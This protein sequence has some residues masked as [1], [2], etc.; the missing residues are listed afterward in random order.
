MPPPGPMRRLA[1]QCQAVTAHHL[2]AAAAPFPTHLREQLIQGGLRGLA[3]EVAHVQ[4]GVLGGAGRRSGRS[5]RSLC[6]SHVDGGGLAGGGAGRW[7]WGA[8]LAADLT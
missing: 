3:I 1:G 5:W 7:G 6:S 4:G 2:R 8:V